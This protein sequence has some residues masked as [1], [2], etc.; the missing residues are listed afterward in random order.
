M[1]ITVILILG[2]FLGML[3]LLEAGRIIGRRRQQGDGPAAGLGVVDGAVFGLMGLLIAFTFSGAAARFDTRRALI[4][5]EANDIGTAWLRLDLL[6]DSLQPALRE[7]F[8]QY[9][10]ARL[11]AYRAVPDEA[12]IQVELARSTALQGEIWALSVAATRQS[13]GST[14]GMLLLPALNA[15]FDITTTRTVAARTHPPMVIFGLL[16][17]LALACSLM[18]GYGMAG[19]ATRSWVHILGFAFILTITVY[20]IMDLEYPR[21]GLIRVTSFDSV[22]VDVRAAMK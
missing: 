15:M 4:V 7:K 19:A 3:A 9:L 8:R 6:P 16:A 1:T 2:L 17:A 5:E 21:L 20:V 13:Q 11:A 22:L 14:A 18:A 12:K 10:D